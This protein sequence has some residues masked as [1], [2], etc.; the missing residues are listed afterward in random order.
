MWLKQVDVG[1]V[2]QV[3]EAGKSGSAFLTLTFLC[4]SD[5]SHVQMILL[6]EQLRKRWSTPF[7]LKV[8]STV[9]LGQW[10]SVLEDRTLQSDSSIESSDNS[11]IAGELTTGRKP[12]WKFRRDKE[13][14]SISL[15]SAKD[16]LNSQL[17]LSIHLA[18]PHSKSCNEPKVGLVA[19]VHHLCLG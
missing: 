13:S 11:I 16:Q 19:V 3:G 4:H 5:D 2:G 18:L 1:E 17:S 15:S 8:N 10:V 14:A 7:Y 9:L 12:A 6:A